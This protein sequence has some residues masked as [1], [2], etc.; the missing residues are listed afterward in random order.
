MV[1]RAAAEL[2]AVQRREKKGLCRRFCSGR[3]GDGGVC[4]GVCEGVG[5]GAA[6]TAFNA[7]SASLVLFYV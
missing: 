3:G 6:C 7:I 4:E 2:H 1:G 5:G